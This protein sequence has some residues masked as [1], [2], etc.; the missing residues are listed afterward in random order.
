MVC[1]EN[2]GRSAAIGLIKHM[3][4]ADGL[5][6]YT[7]WEAQSL[8]HALAHRYDA[9]PA[10]SLEDQVALWKGMRQQILNNPNISDADKFRPATGRG[11]QPGLITRIDQELTRLATGLDEQGR[12]LT[13][14]QLN[15]GKN[16][17]AVT[18][19][20]GGLKRQQ[21]AKAAYFEVYARHTG[22][23]LTEAEDRFHELTNVGR[24]ER[25]G[26]QIDLRDGWRDRLQV[27][28]LSSDQQADMGE[29]NR[30]RYALRVMESE[31]TSKIASMPARPAIRPEHV[32]RVLASDDPSVKV[33]CVGGCGQFGH[34][35]AD[36]PN[37]AE[38]DA[39]RAA[40]DR[41]DAARSEL[42]FMV[43]VAS[44]RAAKKALD[45]GEAVPAVDS[46]GVPLLDNHGGA[47]IEPGDA[48]ALADIEALA[49]EDGYS[50]RKH[51][52]AVTEVIAS[53]KALNS[54]E[55]ALASK[56]GP[57]PPV[58]SF[59]QAVAYNPESSVFVVQM[60][61]YK[62]KT[63]GEE[64]PAKKYVYHMTEEDYAKLMSSPS[65]GEELNR[66]V[67]RRPGGNDPLKF[68]S[69][70]DAAEA[71]RQR[72][73]PTC[74]QWASL[75]SSHQCVVRRD[76]SN[77]DEY[78]H[79]EQVRM[80]RE[81]ARLAQLK[82]TLAAPDVPR[83]RATRLDRVSIPGRGAMSLPSA[84]Q[85]SAIRQSGGVGLGKFQGNY[86]GATVSG[87]VAVWNEPGS[88][89]PLYRVSEVKCS[90]GAQQPC[91]HAPRVTAMLSKPYG[92]QQTT[93]QPGMRTFERPNAAAQ[94]QMGYPDRISYERRME[95]RRE[96]VAAYASDFA[97]SP[98]QRPYAGQARVTATGEVVPPN[99]VPTGW[100]AP[101][102]TTIDVTD[103][104]AVADT[105]RARLQ[106]QEGGTVKFRVSTDPAGGVWVR[107]AVQSSVAQEQLRAA[108]GLPTQPGSRG[109]YIGADRATRHE[110]LDRLAGRSP[111][112]TSRS[113]MR[114]LRDEDPDR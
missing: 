21:E 72:R 103:P 100:V 48:A 34:T 69:D 63:T 82:S 86:F 28:G 41:A 35:V 43:R 45:A 46:A 106:P 96:A 52:A 20:T 56:R 1:R 53:K 93:A 57:V 99:K 78:A 2:K 11:G 25:E 24:A 14:A 44:A 88:G 104:S 4:R 19:M 67:L 61:P 76:D 7:D 90:C 98:E 22:V 16:F 66:L 108:F 10:P 37:K 58:S 111:Q 38:V 77:L 73:C 87:H 3:L 95:G 32:T 101:N 15:I 12:P 113:V 114:T 59:V 50:T 27:A 68:E 9:A 91:K 55:E 71:V 79:R 17:A 42:Q 33:Q 54:A 49:A 94:D 65:L 31:R 51:R 39:A 102:G 92:A 6:S 60:R 29:D 105:V 23:S 97:N 62:L 109:V 40:N 70:A 85:M 81:Q 5:T 13:Q 83:A 47:A 8:T 18:R 80:S 84:A 36:C 89:Q 75:N 26:T 110:M 64:R 30:T 74:G 107:P 112:F